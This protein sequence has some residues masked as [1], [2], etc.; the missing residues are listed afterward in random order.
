MEHIPKV[1]PVTF[2]FGFIK[3][4]MALMVKVNNASVINIDFIIFIL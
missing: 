2:N 3:L 4:A 1:T